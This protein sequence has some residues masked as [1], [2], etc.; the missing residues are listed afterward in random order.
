MLAASQTAVSLLQGSRAPCGTPQRGQAAR[1]RAPHAPGAV[2]VPA[3]PA[4]HLPVAMG[5]RQH[6]WGMRPRVGQ[7]APPSP[8]HLPC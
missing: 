6:G 2:P 1:G 7:P 4:S 8:P 5:S 3:A